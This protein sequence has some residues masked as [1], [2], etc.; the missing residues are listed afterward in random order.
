MI[1][2]VSIITYQN[3]YKEIEVNKVMNERLIEKYRKQ[4]SIKYGKEIYFIKKQL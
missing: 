3:G 1:E 2:I 4:M